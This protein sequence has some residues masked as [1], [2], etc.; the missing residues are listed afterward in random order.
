MDHIV[1]ITSAFVAWSIASAMC[2]VGTNLRGGLVMRCRRFIS[3]P[4]P[5]P[6]S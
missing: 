5:N 2:P 3:T 6:H 4:R 1:Q